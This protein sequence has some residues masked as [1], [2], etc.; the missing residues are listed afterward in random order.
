MATTLDF[1]SFYNVIDG[2]TSTTAQASNNNVNPATL[3]P[4]PRVPLSTREDVDRAVEAARKAAVSWAAVPWEERREAIRKF[5]DAIDENA[6]EFAKLL[7]MQQGKAPMWAKHEIASSTE[8][9]RGLANLSIPVEVIEDTPDRK[10]ISRYTP[11]GVA[12]G[13]VPWNFPVSL[14]CAKLAPAI[15]TGNAF[16]WKPSPFSPHCSL[17]VAEL[18]ARFFPPGVLQVLSG[19]DTLGP[20]LT[21]HPGVNVVNFTGSVPVGKKI[22]E[23]CSRSLKRFT[24]ELGGN[25]AAI[26]CADVDPVEVATKI[27]VVAFCNAGQICIAVKRLYVH[28][29]VYD[30]VLAAL[31]GFA[32]SLKLGVEEDAFVGPV[33]NKPQY[34]RVLGLL[35]EIERAN[36]TLATG[37]TRPVEGMKGYYIAPT[38]ID[39]PPEDSPIV[40]EEQFAPILPVMKWSDESDV[41]RRANGTE[42]GLGA[43][44]WTRDAEQGERI[45]NQLQAGNVWV[46]CHAELQ[47]NTPFPGHKESGFGAEMGVEGLKAFCNVQAVYRRS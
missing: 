14:A 23:T 2:K 9:L 12:V 18:G 21:A 44:V 13:I 19:D 31:V 8:W 46:N 5:A 37:S 4:T 16:I 39:N 22:A 25:D 27:G 10:V 28:E 17:K 24:L 32:Q 7:V 33:A 26:V 41:I 36:L 38:V 1:S 30:A 29:A 20:L 45:S 47:P 3:E 34:E 43:S 15:L 42:L 11:L 6:E 35:A 40:A